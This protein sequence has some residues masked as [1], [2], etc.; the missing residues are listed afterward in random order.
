MPYDQ[1]DRFADQQRDAQGDL[2]FAN[3]L[4]VYNAT[5]TYAAGQGYDET[6]TEHADSP[7]DAEITAPDD[8][9]DR[10]AGGTTAEADVVLYVA[11]DTGIMWAE[12]GTESEHATQVKDVATGDRYEVRALSSEHN[13]LYK[14]AAVEV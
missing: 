10:D 14:I 9:A 5:Q 12:A 1:W 3:S 8:E 13:G 7:I 6:Y 2:G 4:R 11:D